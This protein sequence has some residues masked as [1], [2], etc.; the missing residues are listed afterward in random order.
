MLADKVLSLPMGPY[1]TD[2]DIERVCAVL[3]DAIG[4]DAPADALVLPA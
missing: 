2:A 3:L 1:L 4:Q